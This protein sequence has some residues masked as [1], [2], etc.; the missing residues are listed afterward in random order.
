MYSFM[1]EVNSLRYEAGLLSK[2]GRD[3]ATLSC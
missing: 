3:L 2:Q 1:E